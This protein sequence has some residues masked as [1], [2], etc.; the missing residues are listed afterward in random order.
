MLCSDFPGCSPGAMW[1]DCGDFER[2]TV[3]A[4]PRRHREFTNESAKP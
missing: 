3:T 1:V 4:Q 2:V